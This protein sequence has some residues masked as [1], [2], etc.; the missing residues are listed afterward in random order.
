MNRRFPLSL[1]ES[2]K[3]AAQ[4]AAAPHTLGLTPVGPKGNPRQKVEPDAR[5]ASAIKGD[6]VSLTVAVSIGTP[7]PLNGSHQHWGTVARRAK[8]QVRATRDALEYARLSGRIDAAGLAL[9][10]AGC[11]VIVRRVCPSAGLDDDGLRAAIKHP[12]DAVAQWLLGGKLGERDNDPRIRWC[13]EQSRLG[14][15]SG[16]IITLTRE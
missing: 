3:F 11:T 2:L 1:G 14:R 15:T 10:A 12:V 7:N 16:L 13:Y 9:L 6:A 5:W 4:A 8:E